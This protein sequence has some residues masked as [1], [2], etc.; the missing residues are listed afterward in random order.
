MKWIVVLAVLLVSVACSMEHGSWRWLHPD[1][2]YAAHNL[3]RDIDDCEDFAARVEDR[4]PFDFS[5]NA[6]D[7]GGWGDFQ[8]ELCMER[9]GWKMTYVPSGQPKR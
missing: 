2:Q 8:F 9:R 4:G 6:R 7:Y 3:W 5:S 1:P